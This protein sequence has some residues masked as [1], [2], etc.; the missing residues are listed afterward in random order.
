MD[1]RRLRSLTPLFGVALFGFAVWLL[2]RELRNYHYA[3][4]VR[5]LRNIPQ[6]RLLL[7]VGMTLVS[8]A[9][10]TLYDALGVRYVRRSLS[11]GRIATASLVGYGVSMTLGFPLLTGAPLRYRLYSRWGLAPGEIARIVAFYSTT[12]WLGLLAVGGLA[13]LL[14]P[15]KVPEGFPI[16][17]IWLRPIGALLLGVLIAYFIMAALKTR[18]TIRGFRVEL[19]SLRLAMAQVGA[20]SLDWIVAAGVMYALLPAAKPS[21][22]AFFAVYVAGQAAGHA[23]HVPGGVGVLESVVL[24]FLT[25]QIPA[26]E[27]LGALLAWRAVYYLLPLG[28]A[29]VTLAIHELRTLRGRVSGVPEPLAGLYSALEP[30]VLA[31]AAFVSGAVLLFSAATPLVAGRLAAVRPWMPL[32]VIEIAHVVGAACGAGLLLLAR[33]LQMRLSRAW[34]LAVWLLAIGI[35]ASLLKA[36]DWEEAVILA[37]AFGGL[38]A[39]RSRFYRAAALRDEPYTPGWVAAMALVV[40]AMVG[41]GFFAFK[42]VEYAPSLWL[43]FAPRGDAA[44]FLRAC[45]AVGIV[46][47]AT[48]VAHLLRP[49]RAEPAVSAADDLAAARAIA[50]RSPRADAQLALLGDKALLFGPGRAAFVMY[51]TSG[52]S[53]VAMGDPVGAADE[54]GE[55]AW[56]FREEAERHRVWPVFYQAA[57]ESLP[58]YL[59]MGL[60]LLKLGEEAV[61]DL[62]TFSID[63]PERKAL[64]RARHEAVVAGARFEVVDAAAVPAL[65]PELQ[66]VSDDWLARRGGAEKGFASGRFD[67]AY[68]ANFPAA[69]V[70]VEGRIVAF[71]NL[72]LAAEGTEATVDLLRWSRA[73]PARV[74]EFLFVELMVWAKARGYREF[75]LGMAPLAG[76]QAHALGEQWQE[77]GSLVF[78]H[79][80][81]F[82]DLAGLRRYKERFGAE[83]RLRYLVVPPT[84]PVPRVLDDI[85]ALIARQSSDDG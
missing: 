53:R 55:L 31:V 64:R 16:S 19:P 21:F 50:L 78:R 13:F 47:L 9:V 74:M 11:Y 20:S 35:A 75:N 60:V 27:V 51:G 85:A 12:Y 23:S 65:I 46:L 54:A 10:L 45:G 68:L 49:R 8:Y 7:A 22:P 29:V 82:Q 77:M 80:E 57:A 69:L 52:R 24:L 25:P 30:Q 67:P 15:P 17:E 2:H 56:R 3:D 6:S 41:V 63:A 1:F 58:L 14:D 76:L 26:P 73:A 28:M 59:E 36:L 79:G 70:R 83:W 39:S 4:L 5:E 72:W 66:R 44:R 62:S 38:L 48:A 40:V 33:G 37:A 71:A 34:K 43:Q 18:V 81:H 61:V 84:A 42:H 32:G